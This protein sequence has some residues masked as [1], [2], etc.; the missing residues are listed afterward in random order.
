[1]RPAI[2]STAGAQAHTVMVD[3]SLR[4]ASMSGLVRSSYAEIERAA[5][6]A[7]EDVIGRA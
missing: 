5:A 7:Y 2:S 3:F 1:M 4:A 6:T